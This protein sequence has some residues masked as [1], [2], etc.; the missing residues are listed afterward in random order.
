MNENMVNP[1][2]ELLQRDGNIAGQAGSAE[3]TDPSWA[4]PQARDGRGGA[5]LD[6]KIQTGAAT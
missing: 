3:S 4:T 5:S 6:G 1:T 2:R